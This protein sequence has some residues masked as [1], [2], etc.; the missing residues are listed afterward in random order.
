[1]GGHSAKSGLLA[2]GTSH[3]L[4]NW[5]SCSTPRTRTIDIECT[6]LIVD[7]VIHRRRISVFTYVHIS[8]FSGSYLWRLAVRWIIIVNSGRA[9]G[10]GLAEHIYTVVPARRGLA[11]LVRLHA[12][13][14]LVGSAA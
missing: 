1:M 13:A 5:G 12:A 2:S 11:G 10:S 4:A 8:L 7:G 3:S 9:V 6:V 14:A